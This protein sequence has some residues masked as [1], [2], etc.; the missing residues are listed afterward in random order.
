MQRG[1]CMCAM[2]SNVEGDKI[3]EGEW[4]SLHLKLALAICFL[5]CSISF[6]SMQPSG[7][8][9]LSKPDGLSLAVNK[10]DDDHRFVWSPNR[11]GESHETPVFPARDHHTLGNAFIDAFVACAFAENNRKFDKEV[12]FASSGGGI[13]H[14]AGFAEPS[15]FADTRT[16]NSEG[17]SGFVGIVSALPQNVGLVYGNNSL[18]R[19]FRLGPF[20]VSE[21]VSVANLLLPGSGLLSD[22]PA[23][24]DRITRGL[25][26]FNHFNLFEAGRGLR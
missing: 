2:L 19:P 5:I 21:V 18:A 16:V 17:A 3:G 8:M 10:L 12:K 1:K 15:E 9:Y 11:S 14:I 26:S 4:A 6:A 7:G 24:V 13:V 22:S 20:V 25:N 23:G